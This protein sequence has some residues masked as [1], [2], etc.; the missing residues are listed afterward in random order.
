MTSN[1]ALTYRQGGGTYIFKPEHTGPSKNA[2]PDASHLQ[3]GTVYLARDESQACV[4][5]DG[6]WSDWFHLRGADWN[7]NVSNK[8]ILGTAAA[9]DAGTAAGQLVQLDQDGAL[10]ALDGSK[11]TNVASRDGAGA[12][13]TTYDNAASG[14]PAS[15]V[16]E[17]IDALDATLDGL[18]VVA[19]TGAYRDLTGTP[20]LGSAA[21]RDETDFATAGQGARADSAVQPGD[22]GTAAALDAGQLVQLDADGGL[23]AIDGSKLTGIASANVF[24]E[25]LLSTSGTPGYDYIT[26]NLTNNEWHGVADPAAPSTNLVRARDSYTADGGSGLANVTMM[27]LPGVKWAHGASYLDHLRVSENISTNFSSGDKIHVVYLWKSG[28][29]DT[30]SWVVLESRSGDSDVVAECATAGS[31]NEQYINTFPISKN[32]GASENYTVDIGAGY[33]ICKVVIEF[34]GPYT[35][36][37][38]IG[39]AGPQH[40]SEMHEFCCLFVGVNQEYVP[41][42]SGDA[43][44]VR[45]PGY[46]VPGSQTLNMTTE[47]VQTGML[48]DGSSY[49]LALPSSPSAGTMREHYALVALS[50]GSSLSL[51]TTNVTNKGDAAPFTSE[52][53]IFVVARGDGTYRIWAYGS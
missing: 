40:S 13:S 44:K 15:D 41:D 48:T 28:G 45:L 22:L 42:G 39:L 19:M 35:D 20:T 50:G 4:V 26:L 51:P 33:Y 10:P 18:A 49:V 21:A 14:L 2:R 8:P 17:A 9:L 30:T 32:F 29:A 7:T 27:G 38:F 34:T 6:E 12:G 37:L 23:P 46:S 25:V 36:S 3:D 47:R 11:L 5:V 53:D 16:Q 1:I 24:H 43:A 31:V 52:V